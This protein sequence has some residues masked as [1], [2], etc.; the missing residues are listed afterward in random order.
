MLSVL[1]RF[2]IYLNNKKWMCHFSFQL[3]KS[4]KLN[5]PIFYKMPQGY[6]LVLEPIAQF[7]E[8]AN[9]SLFTQ[10]S[11]IRSKNDVYINV[12]EDFFDTLTSDSTIV[13]KLKVI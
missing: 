1:L 10:F 5:P 8:V 9:T 7:C 12:N 6:S 13:Y 4:T 2:S 3:T 11:V